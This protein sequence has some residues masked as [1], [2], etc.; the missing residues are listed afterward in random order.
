MKLRARV[1]LVLVS[2]CIAGCSR[3]RMGPPVLDGLGL[4]NTGPLSEEQ[5]KGWL[6]VVDAT[7]EA[8]SAP[9]VERAFYTDRWRGIELARP[10]ASRFPQDK[11][12]DAARICRIRIGSDGS[13]TLNG[14]VYKSLAAC[15]SLL[16]ASMADNA[17][18]MIVLDPAPDARFAYILP[19]LA[20]CVDAGIK[21]VPKGPAPGARPTPSKEIL[22]SLTQAVSQTGTGLPAMYIEGSPSVNKLIR[23]GH[24]LVCLRMRVDGAVPY[25][26]VDNAL[27]AA[28]MSGTWRV[29]FIAS[30]D[31]KEVEV[32]V[33]HESARD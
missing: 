31:G 24:P 33:L 30:L 4:G 16:V 26:S 7:M 23:K 6:R 15:R 21:T 10:S 3:K 8:G 5:E 12:P 25:S 1:M 11:Q 18:G 2:L 9:V 32:G 20:V 19:V 14:K 28:V 17:P 13:L 27:M 22:E 29:S